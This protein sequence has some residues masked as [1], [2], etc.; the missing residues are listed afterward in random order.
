MNLS[1]K[2]N[3]KPGDLVERVK[4]LGV[5]WNCVED[6]Y[7]IH[8]TGD[9]T[10]P[11]TLRSVMRNCMRFYD[12]MGWFLPVQMGGRM[13]VQV[14]WR[15][16]GDADWDAL[17][18]EDFQKTRS[19]WILDAKEV[20]THK[21]NRCNKVKGK[22]VKRRRLAV[23]CDASSLAYAACIYLVTEYVDKEVPPTRKLIY[24][25]GKV[26]STT[27]RQTIARLEAAACVLGVEAAR[28]AAPKH[29]MTMEEVHFYTDSTTCLYWM[30]TYKELSVYVG[31]RVCHI[32]DY[33]KPTQ[34]GHVR[35]KS[36]PADDPSR[37][38]KAKV[39]KKRNYST[40]ENR[41]RISF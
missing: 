5:V 12:P 6:T 2:P 1:N 41:C 28:K 23:F 17:L 38:V 3:K 4:T 22:K 32:R 40:S 35:T 9:E 21:I 11:I 8:Y 30:Q 31:A 26:A 36:N 20:N 34:W 10:E 29:K 7:Q 24:S 37:A 39:L 33:T 25:R 27:K 13:L 15:M 19:N 18:P 14:A 16:H